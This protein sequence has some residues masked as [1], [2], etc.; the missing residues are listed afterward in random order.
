MARGMVVGE[1]IQSQAQTRAFDEG[2]DRMEHADDGQR[3]RFIWD[4]AVGRL[5]RAEDYRAPV[6]ALDAPIIADRIYEGATYDDGDR[7]RDVG[8]RRKRREF[9]RETG[10]VDAR[11]VSPQ[12]REQQV[13]V[14]ERE[15]GKKLHETME[16]AKRV[17]YAQGK[18]R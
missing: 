10:L 17:L 16:K 12:W 3:G 14:R 5:V 18:W 1:P 7:V 2:W 11:D 13:K 9:L 15:D 4:A 6:R 8:S